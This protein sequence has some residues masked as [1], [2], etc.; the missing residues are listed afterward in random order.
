MRVLAHQVIKARRNQKPEVRAAARLAAEA[1]IAV[2]Q[3]Q[4]VR[5]GVMGDWANAYRT[6]D[7]EYEARQLALFRQSRT[8]RA[9]T[10][11]RKCRL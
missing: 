2:Q 7:K 6:L 10:L 11:L 4:F 1:A 5:W 8:A 3:A 9:A